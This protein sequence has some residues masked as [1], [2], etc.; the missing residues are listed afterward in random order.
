MSQ[1][2]AETIALIESLPDEMVR[3]VL[4]DALQLNGS[5]G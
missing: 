3:R 5:G 1:I 4:A 2:A